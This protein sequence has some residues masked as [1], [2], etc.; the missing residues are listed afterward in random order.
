M[1]QDHLA[2][3]HSIFD[4][5]MEKFVQERP[6]L[7]YLSVRV[8]RIELI[9]NE[10]AHTSTVDA[11]V[12]RVLVSS[13]AARKEAGRI[14]IRHIRRTILDHAEN[15]RQDRGVFAIDHVWTII[16]A[17]SDI[18]PMSNFKRIYSKQKI[19]MGIVAADLSSQALMRYIDGYLLE[20]GIIEAKDVL[21]DENK[22][23]N[24]DPRA[25]KALNDVRMLK[26]S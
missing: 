21:T 15:F 19:L 25:E 3:Q 24:L 12:D 9:T 18:H 8:K 11:S 4:E 22:L 26:L 14:M 23:L 7:K 6:A 5:K 1:P 2:I 20:Q 17:K 13:I 16:K 10:E